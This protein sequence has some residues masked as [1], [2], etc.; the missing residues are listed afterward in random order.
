MVLELESHLLNLFGALIAPISKVIGVGILFSNDGI[1]LFVGPLIGVTVSLVI[2]S[3]SDICVVAVIKDVVEIES[4]DVS[5][6]PDVLDSMGIFSKISLPIS[7]GST[8]S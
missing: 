8:K 4:V 2:V 5:E 6:E 7:S 1:L 3:L